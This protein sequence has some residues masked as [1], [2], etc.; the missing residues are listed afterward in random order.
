MINDNQQIWEDLAARAQAG[1]KSA[2]SQLLRD[3]IPFSK[4][5]LAP[6]VANRDWIDDITQDVLVSVHKSLNTY[7]PDRPFKPWLAA[8]INFRKTDFLRNHYAKRGNMSVPVEDQL[9]LAA[10]VT[11]LEDM[12]ELKNI[13]REL[14]KLSDQQRQVFEMIKIQGF[15]VEE[16]AEKTGMSE[17][18]VKVSAHRTLAKLKEKLG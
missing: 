3:I 11:S 6:Q 13:D 18:A 1:D 10:D 4:S 7:S 9:D 14:H 17:S 12:A 8:I 5:V 2:Y 16:V 15:S